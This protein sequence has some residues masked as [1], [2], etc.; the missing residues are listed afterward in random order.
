MLDESLLIAVNM[1][2]AIGDRPSY[3]T[4]DGEHRL[5][6]EFFKRTDNGSL[7]AKVHFGT[8]TEGAPG[9]AHGGSVAAALSEAMVFAA[10]T[11]GHGV[12]SMRLTTAFKQM[13]TVSTTAYIETTVEIDGPRLTIKASMTGNTPGTAVVYAEGEGLFM[14]IP[15]AKFGVDGQKVA[16]MFAA[17]S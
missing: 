1:V 12:L 15:A 8:G 2:K 10:W 3:V 16:Q 4:S 6:M 7:V 13:I 9:L 17:L 5:T 11:H 14:A